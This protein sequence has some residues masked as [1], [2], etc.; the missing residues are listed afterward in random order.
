M[1]NWELD[2]FHEATREFIRKEETPYLSG[3]RGEY[4]GAGLNQRF[5][6]VIQTLPCTIGKAS[7]RLEQASIELGIHNL[8]IGCSIGDIDCDIGGTSGSC[9]EISAC[10][11]YC[12]SSNV[13]QFEARTNS[14]FTTL[15]GEQVT[16]ASGSF[17]LQNESIC[18][19]GSRVFVFILPQ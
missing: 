6:S 19:V 1:C 15:N 14:D 13:F 2:S 11:S 17:P 4:G 10:I 12:Q 18:S 5:R 7:D 8:E 16:F 3:L 9:N